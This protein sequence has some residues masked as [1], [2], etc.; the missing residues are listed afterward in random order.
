MGTRPGCDT[1]ATSAQEAAMREVLNGTALRAVV[2]ALYRRTRAGLS[3]PMTDGLG[4]R[5]GP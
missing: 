3:V 1:H 2:R 4:L 5:L